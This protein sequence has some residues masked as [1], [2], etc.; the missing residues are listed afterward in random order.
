[1]QGGQQVLDD[2]PAVSDLDALLTSLEELA[3]TL[4]ARKASITE[5]AA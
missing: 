2:V 5:A 4:V 1:L 3:T